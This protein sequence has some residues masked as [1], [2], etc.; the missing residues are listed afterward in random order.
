MSTRE[1]QSSLISAPQLLF[2]F[3]FSTTSISAEPISSNLFLASLDMATSTPEYELFL[4]ELKPS[5]P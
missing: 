5:A 3:W 4:S 1:A 2:I